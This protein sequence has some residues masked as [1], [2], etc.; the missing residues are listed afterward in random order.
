MKNGF[1]LIELLITFSI[2]AI[3]CVMSVASY[4]V[5]Q[6]K[7]ENEVLLSVL[8]NAIRLARSDAMVQHEKII[9]CHSQDQQ[10]CEGAWSDGFIIKTSEQVLHVFQNVATKGIMHWRTFPIA[11]EQIEFTSSGLADAEDGTIWFCASQSPNPAWAI[12]MN[13]V[14]RVRVVYPDGNGK[15]F[16]SKGKM[17]RC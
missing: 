9:L 7:S 16:D 15:I 4:S 5:F 8:V 12:I 17:L 11:R 10:T 1:T 13:R 14:A 3:I 2:I 6:K